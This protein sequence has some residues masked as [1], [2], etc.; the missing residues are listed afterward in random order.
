MSDTLRELKIKVSE[1]Q[2]TRNKRLM[3]IYTKYRNKDVVGIAKRRKVDKERDVELEE[4][5]KSIPYERR[6]CR[7][8]DCTEYEVGMLD[9]P[10]RVAAKVMNFNAVTGDLHSF[11]H[12]YCE[13][14]LLER[15]PP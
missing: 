12:C 6:Y 5:D 3:N 4:L 1:R 8:E 7:T 2:Y 13:K 9:V 11:I 14:H 15:V 10:I